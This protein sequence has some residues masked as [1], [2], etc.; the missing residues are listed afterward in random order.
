VVN[1][2][3]AEWQR[4]LESANPV[5]AH[6]METLSVGRD[7]SDPK[8]KA[9]IA[10]QVMPLIYDL[11]SEIERD[12][13]RQRLARLLRVDE[14]TLSMD[15]RP[16]ASRYPRSARYARYGRGASERPADEGAPQRGRKT[17]APSAFQPSQV[18]ESHTLGALLRRPDLLYQVD[19]HLQENG[20]GRLSEEDFQ[21][22]DQRTILHILLESV[23]QDIA[24][25][26][27]YVL[28]S[29]SLP[30]MEVADDLLARTARLDPND[31]RVLADL[32][33]AVLHLRLRNLKQYNDHLRF[34][35]EEAQQQ[36]D[37]M[38]GEY[39]QIMVYNSRILNQL[40]KAMGKY[41][42]RVSVIR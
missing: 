28:S 35:Q 18:L 41:S 19:R 1:N 9:E 6:V 21:N 14:R 12:T 36:G 20:L 15:S 32:L 25:P 39:G 5:V 33:R 13:Y 24:E 16:A 10:A 37:L 38:A 3:A 27:N 42:D 17:Q 40:N 34:M 22:A 23:D 4:L 31:E 29:L 30:M 8:V 26:L 2:D 7:L 11:P